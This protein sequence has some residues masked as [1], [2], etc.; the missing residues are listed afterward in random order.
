M[1]SGLAIALAHHCSKP[2]AL[3]ATVTEMLSR[4]SSLI[5]V[6]LIYSVLVLSDVQE[7][8]SVIHT[9]IYIYILF[10]ILVHYGL[11]QDTEHSS[12]CYTV[13][14]CCLSILHIVV[15]IC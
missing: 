15:C 11:L 3:C 5:V 2:P 13:G 6:E 8:D 9:C 12:L 1:A 14:L 7:I 4:V 10:N